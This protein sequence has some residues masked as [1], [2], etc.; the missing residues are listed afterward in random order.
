MQQQKQKLHFLVNPFTPKSKTTTTTAP[1]H[2]HGLL[3]LRS[4]TVA[5]LYFSEKLMKKIINLFKDK[6]LRRPTSCSVIV[7]ITNR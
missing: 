1:K 5:L 3:L 7:W 4:Q 2:K 6:D